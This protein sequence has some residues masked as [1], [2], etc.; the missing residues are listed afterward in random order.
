MEHSFTSFDDWIVEFCITSTAVCMCSEDVQFKPCLQYGIGNFL[1]S[2]YYQYNWGISIHP[3]I[4]QLL[5]DNLGT[6]LVKTKM[7]SK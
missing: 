5:D 3:P 2:T 7:G 6:V 4:T 1:I